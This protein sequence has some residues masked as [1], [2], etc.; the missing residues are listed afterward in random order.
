MVERSYMLLKTLS[1]S[2]QPLSLNECAEILQSSKSKAKDEIKHLN[3]FLNDYSAEIVG[4]SGRG[5]G[6]VLEIRDHEKFDDLMNRIYPREIKRSKTDFT[7]QQA[8]INYIINRLIQQG[9]YIKSDDLADELSISKSQF[10]KDLNLVKK[11]LSDFSINIIFKPYHGIRLKASEFAIRSYIVA[12]Y[13]KDITNVFSTSFVDGEYQYNSMLSLIRSIVI[14]TCE[15]HKYLLYDLVTQNLVTH[16]FVAIM[17]FESNQ[18]AVFE[19]SMK[20]QIEKEPEFQLSA[21]IISEINKSLNVDLPEDEVYYCAIHLC[22]KKLIDKNY[23]FSDELNDLVK[24]M[25]E[26]IYEVHD[27]DFRNDLGLLSLIGLH[28][29]PLINRIKYNLELRNPLLNDIK[30]KYLFAYEL[31]M[32]AAQVINEEYDTIISEHEISYL[33]VHFMLGLD[34]LEN[35]KKYNILVVCSTGRGSASLLK[36]RF[37]KMFKDQINTLEAIDI[38]DVK[39][40]DLMK[41]DMVYSTVPIDYDKKP[42]ILISH[43]LNDDDIK[44][45]SGTLSENKDVTKYLR[46]F[47]KELYISG[48]RAKNREEALEIMSNNIRKHY[49]I[50]DEFLDSV[51]EREELANTCFSELVALPHPMVEMTKE[52]YIAI[53]ILEKPID[54]GERNDMVQMILLGNTDKNFARENQDFYEFLTDLI[55]NRRE[56]KELI[57]TTT[58]EQWSDTVKKYS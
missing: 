50:P 12:N 9:D 1:D 39:K 33:A 7:N 10:S 54:W 18:N 51:L 53:G 14:N 5:N 31:A 28:L 57:K 55:T 29:I 37:E 43:F 34:N 25:M 49:D 4:K 36:A 41:Y 46:Y 58:Y 52:T 56:V 22:G 26:R 27:I 24:R 45:I 16:I 6:Y 38:L 13:D 35:K 2:Q 11:Q 47:K 17:R 21:E 48:I 44:T 40:R 30:T 42:I 23:V 8:R 3:G 15:K 19:E 20:K 32:T